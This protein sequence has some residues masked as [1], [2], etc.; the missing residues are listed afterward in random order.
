MVL[1]ILAMKNFWVMVIHKIV[2]LKYSIDLNY[3]RVFVSLG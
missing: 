1:G 3:I 2:F